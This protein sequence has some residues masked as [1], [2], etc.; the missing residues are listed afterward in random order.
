MTDDNELESWRRLWLSQ[1]GAPIELVRRV[2][3]R[4]VYMRLERI[5]EIFMAIFIG[6]GLL[7]VAAQ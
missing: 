1:P 6:G 2:E 3:R 4:T 5:A 7:S